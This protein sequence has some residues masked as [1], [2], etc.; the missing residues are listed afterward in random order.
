MSVLDLS[1]TS[2]PSSVSFQQALMA[3]R[4]TDSELRT[5]TRRLRMKATLILVVAVAS[6]ADLVLVAHRPL[7]ALFLVSVFTT[8]V[9]AIGTSVMHDANHG[10]FGAAP[11]LNS[12]LAFTADILGASSW[13]WRQ[14]HNSI[15]H[16]NTNVV[17]ID[18]DIEQMPFAR[19]APDQ[20]W[21]RRYRFQHFYLWGLYGLLSLQWVFMS[22]FENILTGRIGSQELK[23]MPSGRTISTILLGKF[24]HVAWALAIPMLFHRWWIVLA[25]Y[26][27]CSWVVGFVLAVFFQLAHCV[28][29]TDFAE[30]STPRRGASFAAHQLRTTANVRCKSLLVGRPIGWL[31]GGLHYQIEHH[32]APRLPHTAYPAMA[33]RVRAV[34]EVN[35]IRY[36]EH[37]SFGAAM[38]SH[39]RWLRRMGQP[40]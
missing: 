26:A 6:F 24:L 25:V 28:D 4:P 38:R 21:M 37:N 14:K 2:A 40:A 1:T 23:P 36:L 32:L 17:G 35:D 27:T 13:L 19:L 8:S 7:T 5:A 31:M 18:T 29:I 30:P 20:P 34:C 22:D 11:L 16:A 9:V 15:H 3:C 33:M 39:Q 12:A 10:A